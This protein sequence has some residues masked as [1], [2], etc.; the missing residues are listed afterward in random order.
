SVAKILVQPD[1]VFAFND[2]SIE[3]GL[4]PA[5]RYPAIMLGLWNN[6]FFF[7]S[8]SNAAAATITRLIDALCGPHGFRRQGVWLV[9]WLAGLAGY[10]MCRQLRRSQ[11]ASWIT[12]LLFMLCGWSFSFPTVGLPVRTVALALCALSVGWLARGRSSNSWLC[13]GIA[14]GC[15]GMAIANNQDVGIFFALA[16][17]AYFLLTR[18]RQ[19]RDFLPRRVLVQGAHLALF[20]GVSVLLAW[21]VLV[22][23]LST[24][25]IAA[26]EAAG[27]T[28][29]EHYDWATQ[30]SLA[31]AETWSL[32]AS[33]YHGAS[34][35]SEQA[36]YWGK[37][38]RAAG[39]ETTKQG[40][41]NFRLA[42]Y[43]LGGV[44]FLALL[45]LYIYLIR[46][47][48]DS[49][50][51]PDDSRDAWILAAL[52][53]VSLFLAWG[54]YFPLYRVFHSLP[55]MGS[56][57]NPDKWLGPF[58]LFTVMG[59]ATAV[60]L[61]L[62]ATRASAERRRPVLR[63]TLGAGV[64]ALSMALIGL[65]LLAVGKPSFI[66]DRQAEGF[67]AAATMI[68][69]HAL[70]ADG[71]LFI[72]VGLM[73]AILL[74]ALKKPALFMG[75]RAFILP[76]IIAVI[77]AGDLMRANQHFLVGYQYG[78]I[79]Q[80]NPLTTFLDARQGHGRIKLLPPQHPLLN[81]W[82]MSYFVA[83][84]Y[85]LFDPVSVRLM[86]PDYQRLFDALGS[87]V[88][89][90]WELGAVRYIICPGD[91]VP[92]LNQAA[93]DNTTFVERLA[94]GATQLVSGHWVPDD[95]VHP[96][97]KMIRVVE[98]TKALPLYRFVPRWAAIPDT[99]AG[100]ATIIN[101]LAS[102]TFSPRQQ[103]FLQGP[104]TLASGTGHS[105]NLSIA[106]HTSSHARIS[107]TSEGEEL[108]VRAI[109][110]DR[111]WQVEIDGKP[112]PLLR[113][114][115]FF[116]GVVIPP[117]QH[118]VTF[119]YSRPIGLQ[120]FSVGM[121]LVLLLVVI[122]ELCRARRKQALPPQP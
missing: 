88:L 49:L 23:Q 118:D 100:T 1:T 28:A 114:N 108:L 116:Q 25:V 63:A 71:W 72:V 77:M 11:T 46:R 45:I 50:V 34:S 59:F 5:N 53:A 80:P 4:N 99:E 104:E 30:W 84:G 69:N 65:C 78:H 40:F 79:L 6:Q 75:R 13:D 17:A 74:V 119:R 120:I 81:N 91:V 93:Q 33:D 86:P 90:L 32:F 52:A 19:R 61:L 89:R 10:W 35:R 20:A 43:A 51:D 60:D 48:R 113:A 112:A 38:G 37:M 64:M 39:W 101:Q 16:L 103:A 21:Q 57:R 8:G 58:T 70:A 18:F 82:R 94:L 24:N 102:P 109:K 68:W 3:Y 106:L 76:T 66:S 122:I 83:K 55:F 41:R 98:Y 115:H 54:R 42:G 62:A 111:D 47:P 67:G 15:L 44:P 2:G 12:A 85:D 97:Q 31:K 73:P 105:G 110:Y 117:G 29:E 96:Q 121:R 22:Q 87:N 36:P 92:Q 107:T 56:I 14:G 9:I 27:R 95:R 26:P 7:G